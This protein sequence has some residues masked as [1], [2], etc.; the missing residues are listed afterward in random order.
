MTASK[1]AIMRLLA[2]MK[3]FEP[4]RQFPDLLP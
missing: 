1:V 2:E 4:L 3:G